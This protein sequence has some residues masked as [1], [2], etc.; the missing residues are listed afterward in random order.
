MKV[1]FVVWELAPFFKLGG[2]GDVA[3]S[4][5][6][7]LKDLEVDVR[8]VLPFYKG[9]KLGKTRKRLKASFKVEFGGKKEKTQVFEVVHPHKKFPVYLFKNET[10][11]S[12]V[13]KT[14]NFAFFNKA[15]VEA[16]KGNYLSFRPNVIHCNDHHAGLIPLLVKQAKLPIKTLFTIHNLA[17]QGRTSTD[18]L[19]KL[20]VEHKKSRLIAWEIKSRKINFL[21]EGIIHAD[22]VS[23]VS[24]TY[25][26]EIMSEEFGMGVEEVLRGKE[27]RVFG[28]LN[29]ISVHAGRSGKIHS[30]HIEAIRKEKENVS[31][32]NKKVGSYL[33]KKKQ[34]K[35]N[36]QKS[37]KLKVTD[38]IPLS[39]FIG[40]LD[41]RQKGLDILH[42]MLRR[43]DV[44]QHQFILLGSGDRSWEK[45]FRWLSTFYPK[46][47]S[48]NFKF[49]EILALRMYTSCDF[50]LIPS[51]FEPCGLIQMLA[52]Y[53]GTIPVAHK[54]GGLIDSIKDEVNG[55][56]FGRYTS[57]SLEHAYNKAVVMWH[58]DK[59]KYR[60]MVAAA[61]LT[62]FSW[63][64]SAKEYLELYNKLVRETL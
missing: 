62:D 53:F 51:K 26:R 60:E 4:L 2:L 10:Y 49:D 42:K 34:N 7:A 18:V 11:L 63:E 54:T 41:P 52:M 6:G 31:I 39:C 30:N 46:N 32:L 12:V 48:C 59:R 64:K 40:R 38:K 56:L 47:I 14:E 13:K 43:V 21:M 50:I 29:G 23:T 24:P 5:P 37:L 19:D 20:G 22:I 27:G 8:V 28:I 17:Y 55:F 61:I 35:L 45:R 9:V 16:V 57:L 58:K 44:E 33:F 25:A 3:R 36:L 15:V 1:L